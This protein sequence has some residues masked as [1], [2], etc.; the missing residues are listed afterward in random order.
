MAKGKGKRVKAVTS[1]SSSSTVE[2]SRKR[3]KAGRKHITCRETEDQRRQL[4][5]Q[6]EEEDVDQVIFQKNVQKSLKKTSSLEKTVKEFLEGLQDY[7]EDEARFKYSLL[8]SMSSQDCESARFG[9]QESWIKLLLNIEELQPSL[10]TLLLEKLPEFSGEDEESVFD[11]SD[12]SNLPKLILDK[13]YWLGRVVKAKEMTNK[14]LEMIE[15]CSPA[16]QKEIINCISE[17]VTDSEHNDVAIKLKEL[18]EQ[19]SSLTIPALNAL[20]NLNVM[21]ELL[22]EVCKSALQTLSSADLEDLPVIVKFI[23]RT[24]TP[25]TSLEVIKRVTQFSPS[26]SA[27]L[28]LVLLKTKGHI[29]QVRSYGRSISATSL[30]TTYP[31]FDD[32]DCKDKTFSYTS[33]K[34]MNV[35]WT[36]KKGDKVIEIGY[37]NVDTLRQNLL[38]LLGDRE[39]LRIEVFAPYYNHLKYDI[40][41]E[42]GEQYGVTEEVKD[43]FYEFDIDE[44]DYLTKEEIENL[45]LEQLKEFARRVD[46]PTVPP[47]QPNY[48]YK[49]EKE[50]EIEDAK[51]EAEDKEGVSQVKEDE[52]EKEDE[53]VDE[54]KEDAETKAEDKEEEQ[55]EAQEEPKVHGHGHDHHDHDEL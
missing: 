26:T 55:E 53:Q 19:N 38:V 8:P 48:E 2:I 12:S 49:E 3:S 4:V 30:F 47:E 37:M 20:N 24:V 52:E 31:E 23:L 16:V 43:I 34:E 41:P 35:M 32:S 11:K 29:H 40:D 27:F 13:F 6:T 5:D 45:T 33:M 1:E 42:E 10:I 50:E 44:K 51:E 22:S 28:P 39:H 21:P 15:V 7:V 46:L 18:M 14:M 17:A 25:S 36:Y 9:Q 54:D